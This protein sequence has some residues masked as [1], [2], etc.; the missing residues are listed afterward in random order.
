MNFNW[1]LQ[2]LAQMIPFNV[3]VHAIIVSITYQLSMIQFCSS[4]LL[5]CI[6][7]RLKS[8]SDF[9]VFFSASYGSQE[10]F[11]I[12]LEGAILP[13]ISW[14]GS[15]TLELAGFRCLLLSWPFLMQVP[16]TCLPEFGLYVVF[17]QSSG[18][19]RPDSPIPSRVFLQADQVRWVLRHCI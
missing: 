11:E 4:Q 16:P 13:R 9:R 12:F 14:T 7:R 3:L 10:L 8:S 15:L 6:L 2:K 19:F 5:Y 1:P 18:G 17:L